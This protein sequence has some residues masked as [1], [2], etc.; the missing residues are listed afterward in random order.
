MHLKDGELKLYLD[1]EM[2][3]QARQQLQQHLEACPRCQEKAD[4]MIHRRQWI[5][6]QIHRPDEQV[7]MP[8][9]PANV[10]RNRLEARINQKTKENHMFPK[11]HRVPR[12]VWVGVVVVLLLAV[13]MVFAPMRAI[14]N[15]FLGLFRV[16][17]I[18]VIQVNPGGLPAQLGDSSQLEAMLNKDVTYQ[19]SGE[20]QDVADA[21]EA[22]TL[23]NLPVRLPDATNDPIKLSYQP[24]GSASLT[25]NIE[26]IRAILA[27][28]GR[29]D[30]KLPES[31]DGEVIS[32]DVPGIVLA[33]IGTCEFDA[34]AAREQGYD[35][36]SPGSPILSGCTSLLQFRNPSISAPPDLDIQNIGVA[37]L[38]VLG[39]TQEE[40]ER[41]ARTVDW[42]TTF[43]IPIPRYD[44]SYQD[45]SVDGTN[46]TLIL[47][48]AGP[49]ASEYLLIWLKDGIVYALTGSGGAE[50]ALQIAN[51]LK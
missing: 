12:L 36:D 40:A 39:M 7:E 33:Q 48:N 16:Q 34:E 35:P 8:G 32:V 6:Q 18:Q 44:A 14:A 43:V 49:S 47:R 51:S 38:Q 24:G 11:L 19:N 30:I 26:N 1:N 3:S 9:L 22:S 21:T 25:V 27:E 46:G 2:N 31:L 41:F 20:G 50:Q 5:E 29:S 28:I 45:V 4:E 17:Q 10:A 13:S 15:S 37:Y 42:S 23:A